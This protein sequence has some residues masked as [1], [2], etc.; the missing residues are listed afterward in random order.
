MGVRAA[1]MDDVEGRSKTRFGEIVHVQHRRREHVESRDRA[2][3]V[4]KTS[5]KP[6]FPATHAQNE[7]F[8]RYR[9]TEEL[10]RGSR[11]GALPSAPHQNPPWK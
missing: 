8:G 10:A 2:P 9:K 6:H 5:A 11:M 3:L 4:L 7:Q 1:W